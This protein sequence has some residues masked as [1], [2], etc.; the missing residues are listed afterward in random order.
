M[1]G[2]MT[3]KQQTALSFVLKGLMDRYKHHLFLGQHQL[4]LAHLATMKFQINN[5]S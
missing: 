3:N 2:M 1:G 4:N 5:Q